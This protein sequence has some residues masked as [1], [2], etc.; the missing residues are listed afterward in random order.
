MRNIV[1][2]LILATICSA[3]MPQLLADSPISCSDILRQG[4]SEGDGEYLVDP[5][6]IGG[7]AAIWVYC[8]MTNG[9]WQLI[10]NRKNAYFTPDH[11][12]QQYPSEPLNLDVNSVA[13]F[14]P[15]DAGLWRWEISV[16]GGV[17]WR[18]ITTAIPG[19]AFFETHNTV[20]NVPLYQAHDNTLGA[21]E[22]LYFQTFTFE[23]QCLFG[24]HSG[25][26]TW[27]GIVNVFQGAGDQWNPGIGGHSDSCALDST[28]IPGDNYTW[29]D[30]DLEL[31]LSDYKD[32]QG[33]GIGG[34]NCVPDGPTDLYR[35]RFWARSSGALNP[36]NGHWYQLSPRP[37]DGLDDAIQ[38]A[39]STHWLGRPGYVV[40]ILS[41]AE[42]D[43]LVSVFGGETLYLIGYTDRDEEEVWKWV[44]GE[45]SGYTFWASGE[46]N[47]YNDEDYAV[48]N[49]Q[50]AVQP[51]PQP[52]GA[53]NDLPGFQG[54]AIFE[55][56]GLPVIFDLKPASCPNSLNLNSKGI[57]PAAV[58]GTPDFEVTTIDPSSLRLQGVPPLR[59]SWEDVS[60]PFV[61]PA[62]NCGECTLQGADGWLDMTLK[63][64][65]EA[66]VAA[67][68]G[69]QDGAC[70]KVSLK[71]N[72]R[73]EF[74][75]SPIYGAD[76]VK[77][78]KK[79][80]KKDLVFFDD[81]EGDDFDERWISGST[82]ESDT[83]TNV[84]GRIQATENCNYIETL[85]LFSGN[86]RIEVDVEKVGAQDHGC[87]DFYVE[88]AEIGASGALRFDTN[89]VD[90]IGIGYLW[91]ICGDQY[92]MDPSASNAGRAVL[93][94]TDPYIQ[95]LFENTDGNV[96]A[97]GEVPVG[98]SGPSPIRIW[99]AAYPDSPRY[100]D[101]VSIYQLDGSP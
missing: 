73:E 37:V 20:I 14:I 4:L 76:S 12:V 65:K 59:W 82:C 85:G 16:D 53:W 19:E 25:T 22:P 2:S 30:G 60:T 17:S 89:G 42:K 100:I 92:E 29:G 1:S 43:F 15:P 70:I 88:L 54:Y 18:G 63:F 84:G 41:E 52:P 13:W 8:D 47:N 78:I 68:G 39:V 71:G 93:T 31:Y 34:T 21:S 9:G 24:C 90:A 83:I 7:N 77:I 44:S 3:T 45:P 98:T 66:V 33:L 79:G 40:S 6:G 48:M 49:W 57:L 75:G 81:F 38:L 97:T 99:L 62:D 51:E 95:F 50:H 32:I 80:K 91:D 36:D 96:L 58:L 101:N 26:A 56:G 72:L 5:D 86:L 35:Y 46:P 87:W 28:L 23:D 67:L 27:W 10:Y 55:Y 74:G 11:M 94:Y 69:L 64:D 61:G